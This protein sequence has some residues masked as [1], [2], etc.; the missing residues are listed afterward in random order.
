[1]DLFQTN[2]VAIPGL[3]KSERP[4]SVAFKCE[5]SFGDL[6][7]K[8]SGF[9]SRCTKNHV[10]GTLLQLLAFALQQLLHLSPCNGYPFCYKKLN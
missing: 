10:N 1:M 9:I 2:E 8:F 6:N 4:K 7:K 5:S 3:M